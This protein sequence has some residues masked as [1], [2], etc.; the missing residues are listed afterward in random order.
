MRSAAEFLISTPLNSVIDAEN[1]SVSMPP[2]KNKPA[3][4]L[5]LIILGIIIAKLVYKI[6]FFAEFVASIRQEEAVFP[7]KTI[8]AKHAKKNIDCELIH[9]APLS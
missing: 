2:G 9:P 1:I 8:G 5:T 7:S 4:S 6:F 3:Q